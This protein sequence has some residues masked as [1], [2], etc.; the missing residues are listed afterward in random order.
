VQFPILFVKSRLN[1]DFQTQLFS[2]SP[3][4]SAWNPARQ[5]IDSNYDYTTAFLAIF[6]IGIVLDVLVLCLPIRPIFNLQL[7]PSRKIKIW[8]I[9]WLGMFCVVCSSARFYYTYMELENVFVATAAEKGN[10]TTMASMWSELEPS[11]A[12]IA[13]CLPTYGPLLKFYNISSMI[14]S[15][16]SL[17][18][19]SSRTR[20]VT[21][22]S[23]TYGPSENS[24]PGHNWHE[25]R[26]SAHAYST[27]IGSNGTQ[28]ASGIE[29]SAIRTKSEFTVTHQNNL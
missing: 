10:I 6:G 14:R 3:I 28:H 5:L 20:S 15:A 19:L 13:A 18:T 4:S 11:A 17:F 8:M 21:S 22:N 1:H 9:L 27:D 26:P 24:I 29:E 25:L 23:K 2:T 12:I 7:K 16:R